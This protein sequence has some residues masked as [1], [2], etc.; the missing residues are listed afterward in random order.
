MKALYWLLLLWSSLIPL[1][2]NH[3]VISNAFLNQKSVDF[4]EKISSELY[5]KTGVRL[6]I[7]SVDSLQA[8][9]KQ[10]REKFKTSIL[11]DLNKPYGVIFFIKSHKK[12]DIVLNPKID[13]INSD[14]IITEYMVP[15]L[16]QDKKLSNP[17]ISASIL[18][19]YA[20]LAE[21]I[22]NHFHQEL[23]ENIIV[24]KSGAKNFVHY[25]FLT[26]LGM[27]FLLVIGVY[28]FGRKKR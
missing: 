1:N 23:P 14:T 5:E 18:N 26:M 8:E 13:S 28:V 7:V 15:I 10:E 11:K 16:M 2:A 17:A 25:T 3:Y 20:Q 6:Y 4:V 27:M 22:A 24:D 12:I 21:E 19:G 9:G